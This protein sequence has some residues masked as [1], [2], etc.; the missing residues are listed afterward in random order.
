MDYLANPIWSAL[1]TRHVALSEG[2]EFAR[3]YLPDFSLLAGLKDNSAESFERLS[4]FAGDRTLGI[5]SQ[6]RPTLPPNW[7]VQAEFDCA[8]MICEKL[9]DCREHTFEILTKADVPQMKELVKLTQPGP[10]ADR[11]IEFG[12]FI[13][14]KDGDKLIAMTGERMKVPGHDEISGVCTHPD[15]QGKGYARAL[16]HAVATLIKQRGNKPFLHVRSANEAAIRSYE[17]VGFKT[18][19]TLIFSVIKPRKNTD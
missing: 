12:T 9:L 7:D 15:Y 14:I 10:F 1:S 13:G 8:Q 6:E 18:R 4:K 5:C 11:T 16:V 19:Q 3:C 17:A 2:D